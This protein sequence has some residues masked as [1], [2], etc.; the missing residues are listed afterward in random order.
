MFPT[1][2]NLLTSADVNA[3]ELLDIISQHLKYLAN[4]FDYDSS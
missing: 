3:K 4:N 1:S 2:S